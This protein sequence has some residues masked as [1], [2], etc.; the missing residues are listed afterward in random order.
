MLKSFSRGQTI[1]ELVVAM[2]I[3]LF[4]LFAIIY[5]SRYGVLSE[6]AEL[7]LRYGGITGFQN[8]T[9]YSAAN[10][11]ANIGT[12]SQTPSP[13]AGAPTTILTGGGPFPGPSPAA[14][15]QPDTDV[16]SPASTCT[17]SVI[18]FGGAQ[19]LATHYLGT[20]IVNVTADMDVPSYLHPLMGSSAVVSTTAQFAHS[21]F[22]G[23]ILYC[24]K[25]VHDRVWGAI[26]AE[27]TT[28]TPPPA[29]ANNGA[30]H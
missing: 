21:A 25:E 28:N 2:P 22:P 13:C 15:W 9:A 11:Y 6:R 8:G 30:C 3:V 20:T 19:F 1:I 10:I 26:T 4:V 7:A 18:G 14:F 23:L 24:S 17:S 29:P 16:A 5:M 12:P 27:S